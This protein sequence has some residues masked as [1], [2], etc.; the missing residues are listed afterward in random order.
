VACCVGEALSVLIALAA[1]AA[2]QPGNMVNGIAM[3]CKGATVTVAV[4]LH[5]AADT[6]SVVRVG[7]AFASKAAEVMWSTSEMIHTSNRRK[8]NASKDS[9]GKEGKNA[10]ANR[11][12]EEASVAPVQV[13]GQCIDP[14]VQAAAEKAAEAERADKAQAPVYTPSGETPGWGTSTAP[15]TRAHQ[16][17]EPAQS[18]TPDV[19]H[20]PAQ[21]RTTMPPPMPANAHVYS[22]A[23]APPVLAGPAG[24]THLPTDYTAPGG[25]PTSST[26]PSWNNSVSGW[27]SVPIVQ[28]QVV[29][30]GVT[31]AEVRAELRSACMAEDFN[32]I[33][34][35]V[36]EADRLG[37]MDEAARGGRRLVQMRMFTAA[38]TMNQEEQA[39]ASF[40]AMDA[41]REGWE[42]AR[43]QGPVAGGAGV[44]GTGMLPWGVAQPT[45][46]SHHPKGSEQRYSIG[47][48]DDVLG[49]VQRVEDQ[50]RAEEQT[51][52]ES[53]TPIQAEVAADEEGT[54][55]D[56]DDTIGTFDP[57]SWGQ[58]EAGADDSTQAEAQNASAGSAEVATSNSDSASAKDSGSA[59]S[60]SS[61]VA[62]DD[63][64]HQPK[65]AVGTSAGW[66]TEEDGAINGFDPS[67]WGS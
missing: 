36:Y 21:P 19:T 33:Q 40:L 6:Q 67:N 44:S 43:G 34:A 53:S 26:L 63:E 35:A 45:K 5:S 37:M 57:S 39:Q 32:R 4:W 56:E 64:A 61:W 66:G 8:D 41:A 14:V 31:P 9:K 30:T 65:A 1:S 11:A 18:Y 27:P 52:I 46:P 59:D 55:T 47:D 42:Q 28:P 62:V 17:P 22:G 10:P 2:E 20:I 49:L 12:P 24:W 50:R 7:Q 25:F 23:I 16:L 48:D 58:N 51:G 15:A 54:G 38:Q 60:L 13:C 29:G 3:T